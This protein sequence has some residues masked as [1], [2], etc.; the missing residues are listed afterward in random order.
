MLSETKELLSIVSKQKGGHIPALLAKDASKRLEG[1]QPNTER[2]EA[3]IAQLKTGEMHPAL[4]DK[5]RKAEKELSEHKQQ[6]QAQ[7]QKRG[8]R[9]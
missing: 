8:M 3:V 6:Q 9:L 5:I 7:P 4:G 2:A 1:T